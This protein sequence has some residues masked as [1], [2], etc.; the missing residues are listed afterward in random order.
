MKTFGE[1]TYYALDRFKPYQRPSSATAAGERRWSAGA[2]SK[3]PATRKRKARR[4]FAAALWLG[5]II[6]TSDFL[7]RGAAVVTLDRSRINVA[8]RLL[9]IPLLVSGLPNLSLAARATSERLV[10]IK[11]RQTS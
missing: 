11:L 8:L 10:E 1:R 2:I 7:L 4:L 9:V 3:S 5:G 6:N